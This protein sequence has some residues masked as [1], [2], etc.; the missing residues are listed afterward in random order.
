MKARI[1]DEDFGY[2]LYKVSLIYSKKDRQDDYDDIVAANLYFSEESMSEQ[3]GR[4]DW[5]PNGD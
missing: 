3:K 1:I 4:V 5:F 2:P